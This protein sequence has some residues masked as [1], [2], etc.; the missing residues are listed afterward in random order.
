MYNL[1]PI[2]IYD[3]CTVTQSHIELK[4]KLKYC[5][6]YYLIITKYNFG[7]VYIFLN[8]F[9]LKLENIIIINC[10]ANFVSTDVENMLIYVITYWLLEI[11]DR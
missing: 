2:A 8:N 6:I 7:L 11:A 9:Y 10:T 4:Y 5:I 1:I 3:L